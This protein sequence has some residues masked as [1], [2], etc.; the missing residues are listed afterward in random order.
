M[1]KVVKKVI[2]FVVHDGAVAVFRHD[3][4]SC[5]LQVPAGT[6]RDGE[7]P[8]A[9][10]LREAE[11]E[12]GLSGLRTVSFLGRYQ[13]DISPIR[14]EIQDRY[15]YLLAVDGPVP[16]RWESFE[17]H[18]GTLPPTPFHFFWLPLGS[19]ELNE[20]VVGQGTFLDTVRDLLK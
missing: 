6:L 18:D 5:G 1:K 12:T 15:V 3:D 9:G 17:N 20:L 4:E 2:A 10:A 11:E 16:E 14:E 13:W 8:E 19:P 7:S